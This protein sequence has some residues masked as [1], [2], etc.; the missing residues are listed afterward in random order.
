MQSILNKTLSYKLWPPS[1]EITS[2]LVKE[3][4]KEIDKLSQAFEEKCKKTENMKLNISKT[5]KIKKGK[6]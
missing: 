6:S 1:Q 2:S 3:E 5:K 4:A